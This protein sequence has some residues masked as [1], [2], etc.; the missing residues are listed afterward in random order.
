[1]EL[2]KQLISP[3]RVIIVIVILYFILHLFNLTLLPIFNDESIY[4]DWGWSHTHIPGMLYDSQLDAKQPLMIWLFGFFQNFISDPLYAGRFVSVLIGFTTL[5]GIYKLSQT[6][7]NKNIA[8]FASIAY[9]ITPIFVFFNR[10]ALLEGGV[11]SIGIWSCLALIQ[12]IKDPTTKKSIVLGIILGIGFFIKTSALLFIFSSTAIIFWFILKKQQHVFLKL[13]GI[14]LSAFLLTNF[15]VFLNPVF[16]EKFHT[17]SRYAY[18]FLELFSFPIIAWGKNILG[19]FEIGFVFMT[20]TIFISGI[21]GVFL[22]Y[23]KRLK[24]QSI[25]LLFFLISLLLELLTTRNQSQRYLISFLPFLVIS[26]AYIIS[27]LWRTTLLGKI[28]AITLFIIPTIAT[29]IL[30]TNPIEYIKVTSKVSQY[31]DVVYI[32]GQTS[33]YGIN[34]ALDYM[35]KD[36]KGNPAMVLFGFNIGNPESAINVYAQR[37]ENLAPMHI[38]SEMFTA[39]GKIDC[40][41]SQY[42]AYLVTRNDQQMGL[43]KYFTLTKSFFNPDPKYS[44]KI[45]TLKKKCNGTTISLSDLYGP[46]MN[47]IFQMKQGIY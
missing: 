21:I 9:T 17:N 8:I 16:W 43:E 31:A 37:S 20:P 22:I 36:S 40:M 46:T 39:F 6:L 12:F 2:W 5:I 29:G 1:M 38:D 14:M 27:L 34:E 19:T 28:I 33:G 4:V 23:K 25:F 30:I 44:I 11:A 15:L 35:Y 13:Y 10:Q 3:H 7:F 45:Y 47:K 32:S 18:T 26:C 41:T 24:F 42:P